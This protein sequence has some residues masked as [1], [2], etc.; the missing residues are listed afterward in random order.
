[1]RLPPAETAADRAFA[2]IDYSRALFLRAVQLLLEE[3]WFSNDLI[4]ALEA[5]ADDEARAALDDAWRGP[6]APADADYDAAVDGM[7]A[8]A[9]T[10]VPAAWAVLLETWPDLLQTGARDCAARRAEIKHLIRAARARVPGL[11]K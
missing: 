8:E 4:S 11:E 1:M 9:P 6:G 5:E 10:T 2:D 3:S 7:R